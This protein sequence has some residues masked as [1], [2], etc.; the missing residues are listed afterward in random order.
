MLKERFPEKEGCEK[1]WKAPIK[2]ALLKEEDV[3]ELKIVKDYVL[4]KGKLYHKMLRGI[5]SRCVGHKEAQRKL[6]KMHSITCGFCREVSLYHRLQRVS[7][8]WP[9]INK[10]AD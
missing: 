7:F 3:V 8:Y 5:L 1:D 6:E 4:M 9:N 10:E 2:E